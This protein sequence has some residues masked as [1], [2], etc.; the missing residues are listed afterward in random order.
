MAY[1]VALIETDARIVRYNTPA[2]LAAAG[3]K[4]PS[5]NL[6]ALVNWREIASSSAVSG[7]DVLYSRPGNM[8]DTQ[9]TASKGFELDLTYNPTR[10]WRFAVNASQQR[11]SRSNIAPATQEYLALRID[12][13]LTGATSNLLSDESGQPVKTRIYDTLLNSLNGQLAREGQN[14]SELREWR[15]NIVTN[16]QFSTDSRLA[17]W[18]VGGAVRWQDKAAIGY[19]IVFRD[20]D[21][22]NLAVPD[23]AN[24]YYGPAETGV[25]MWVG[26]TCKIMK[27][28][29][30][31][32]FQ[33]NIRNL[34]DN[35]KF[36]PVAAQPDG[37]I[38]SWLAPVGRT[39]NFRTAFEF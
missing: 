26:Y 7:V 39:I 4:G 21:G 25:D 12:E 9:S 35:D 23:L 33:M 30:R 22:R 3:W 24:P 2:A 36:V 20:F 29:A 13:W 17:G 8:Q 19:P 32:R 14:V 31:L 11:A 10:N 34:L 16:Y 6:K 38:V 5:S 27:G 18:S 1:P 37:S 28:K 15:A